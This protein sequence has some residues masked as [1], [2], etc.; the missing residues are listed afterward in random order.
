MSLL[1]TGHTPDAWRDEGP[2]PHVARHA[3]FGG[4]TESAYIPYVR[5]PMVQSEAERAGQSRRAATRKARA[6]Q[7]D[8]PPRPVC[9]MPLR[10]IG[11]PCARTPG[12][13]WDHRSAAAL[14]HARKMRRSNR[15]MG[16]IR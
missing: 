12:H 13:G 10:N 5:L 8:P 16:G 14:E 6:A 2:A 7:A 11:E 1:R 3:S 15:P 9:G 4:N